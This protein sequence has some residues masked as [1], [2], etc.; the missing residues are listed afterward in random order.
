M[1]SAPEL[2][3]Q[4]EMLRSPPQVY[5]RVRSLLDRPE[6]ALE[7]LA[8][9]MAADPALT[10]TVLR[11][12]N[13]AIYGFRGQI[14]SVLRALQVL[15]IERVHGLVLAAALEASF[16][17]VRTDELDVQ[18]F[19]RCSVRCA[20]LARAL[21]KDRR[22]LS[23]RIFI[24][25][26]LADIGHL[27]MH[28]TVPQ[29]AGQARAEALASGEALHLVERRLI[30]CDFA[31]T[32]AALLTQWGVPQFFPAL[33]GAQ[34]LPRLGGEYAAAAA[35]LEVARCVAAVCE[36]HPPCSAD[37]AST[38][39]A[40]SECSG[41][42]LLDCEQAQLQLL[43]ERIEADVQAWLSVFRLAQAA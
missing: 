39:C 8:R 26:L 40:C 33:I 38:V 25:G 27:V 12:A 34:T 7:T 37:F 18:R 24:A 17:N 41:W 19:W 6:V 36:V 10:A 22:S 42:A 29:L 15:G 2:A 13:S 16:A 14:D 20:L 9:A 28:A 4:V 11:M 30:G 43:C 3:S 31:E 32:G 5:L 35:A 23:E 21:V 1:H